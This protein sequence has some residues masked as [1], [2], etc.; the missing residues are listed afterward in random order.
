MKFKDRIYLLLSYTNATDIKTKYPNFKTILLLNVFGVLLYF[1]IPTFL[2]KA[3]FTLI[4]IAIN[5]LFKEV[6]G[7]VITFIPIM[8]WVLLFASAKD[9]P[10][11]W[12]RPIDVSTLYSWEKKLGSFC[13]K[14]NDY[15]NVFLDLLAW[16]PYGIIHYI[17]PFLVGIYLML[18]YKPTYTSA[19][20]FFFGIM[21]VAGVITQ[22]F[23][24]TSPPWYYL[25]NKT[26]PA[27]Y[28]MHG[29]PAGLQR[30]DDL[31][32]ISFYNPTFTG[33]PL[34]WGAWPSLHSGFA[35]YSAV[36][37]TYLYPKIGPFFFIYVAWI[38]WATM[39]LGHHYL[40][41]LIGGFVY[42]FVSALGAVIYLQIK[43]PHHKDYAELKSIM[44]QEYDYKLLANGINNKGMYGKGELSES[45]KKL[46]GESS[47][48][49]NIL[50]DG[51]ESSISNDQNTAVNDK[52]QPNEHIVVIDHQ[53]SLNIPNDQNM[54]RLSMISNIDKDSSLDYQTSMKDSHIDITNANYI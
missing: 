34:P 37:L 16:L 10:M 38:W 43:K 5:L 30:I 27:D 49:I 29:D 36:F 45:V 46:L 8:L 13:F 53:N 11:S 28:S 9:I 47:G 32:H 24:P 1:V 52:R 54:D 48:T 2:A 23:W 25:K 22:L 7:I 19:Y 17:M 20:L 42:A 41:D 15:N 3:I 40:V 18:F 39:Y 21:N 50:N 6:R 14:L 33:N 26:N 12:R 4:L 31:F 44:V 35:S 51:E